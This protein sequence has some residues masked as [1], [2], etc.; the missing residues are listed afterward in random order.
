MLCFVI[1]NTILLNLLC[2]GILFW[3]GNC[4]SLSWWQLLLHVYARV[5]QVLWVFRATN[6]LKLFTG[7]QTNIHTV[8]LFF[9]ASTLF[10]W[11][12]L[13]TVGV[14]HASPCL[15]QCFRCLGYSGLGISWNFSLAPKLDST[16]MFM[17]LRCFSLLQPL[18]VG[19]SW[20]QLACNMLLH[21][22]ASASG[23]LGIQG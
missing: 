9:F 13:M 7:P 14:R 22:Y 12:K 23:A 20:W 21:V 8:T 1:T 18:L 10:S 19:A 16:L 2:F 6:F 4:Q 15:S 3:N 11:S 17:L 5:F